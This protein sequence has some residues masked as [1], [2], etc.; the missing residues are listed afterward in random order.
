MAIG[1]SGDGLLEKGILFL[2]STN[3]IIAEEG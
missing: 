3:L 1:D 2:L